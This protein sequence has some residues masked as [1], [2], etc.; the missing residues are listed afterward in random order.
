MGRCRGASAT[1]TEE[2]L[3]PLMKRCLLPEWQAFLSFTW[4]AAK[5]RPA[6]MRH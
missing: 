6:P 3:P 1:Y 2:P 5:S 4:S